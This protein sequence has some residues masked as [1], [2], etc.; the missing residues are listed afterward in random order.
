MIDAMPSAPALPLGPVVCSAHDVG[1]RSR[2]ADERV[3]D[4]LAADRGVGVPAAVLRAEAGDALTS[5]DVSTK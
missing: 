4:V 3:L 5:A 2:V 1:Q